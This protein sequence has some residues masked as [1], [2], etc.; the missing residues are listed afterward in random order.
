MGEMMSRHAAHTF[1]QDIALPPP[2]HPC[3]VQSG[4]STGTS[5]VTHNIYVGTNMTSLHE[6]QE[7]L[8]AVISTA[9]KAASATTH[10]SVLEVKKCELS[11]NL[12]VIVCLCKKY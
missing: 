9:F 8:I 2:P 12:I 6:Q 11:S 5:R 10:T 7:H 3:A 4:P 1:N